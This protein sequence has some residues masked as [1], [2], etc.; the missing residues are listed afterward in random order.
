MDDKR[1]VIRPTAEVPATPVDHAR[2]ATIQVLL[3]PAE[4]VPNFVMRRFTLEPGGRIPAHR[5]DLIEH[6][7][8]VLDGE[9]T[10]SLD[11][12]ERTV[13]AGDCLFI[14]PGVVHWYENR[15]KAAVRFLCVVPR[16]DLYR[17]EWLE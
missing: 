8:L 12:E 15:K 2:G 4:G 9:M 16:T 17:T 5:H 14:P 10:V 7:Q 11:G 1:F 3:G 6:E 13:A